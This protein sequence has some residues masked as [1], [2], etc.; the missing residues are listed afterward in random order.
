MSL[1]A[2]DFNTT[3]GMSEGGE[4]WTS[5]EGVGPYHHGST[6]VY[7]ERWREW[8]QASEMC[9]ATTHQLR[10]GPTFFPPK[11]RARK[12]DHMIISSQDLPKAKD[13]FVD[14]KLARTLQTIPDKNPRD[15]MPTTYFVNYT[16]PYLKS[17]PDVITRWD[18]DAMAECLQKG[19]SRVEFLKELDA[20]YTKVKEEL[21]GAYEENTAD[22][23][24]EIYKD[25]LIRA[26]KKIFEVKR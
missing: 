8:F 4:R 2:G 15:H 11:G 10:A 24:W 7:P 25:A 9:S 26:S 5:D 12:L 20:E 22:R 23:H 1:A 19:T 14:W 18:Y 3:L 6:G 17:D 13:A 16:H 21:E